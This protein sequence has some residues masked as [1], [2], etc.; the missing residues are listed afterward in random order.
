MARQL[1]EEYIVK[2]SPSE[3]NISNNLSNLIAANV[4]K[5]P[6]NLFNEAQ[7]EIYKLM[8]TNSFPR[9]QSSKQYELCKKILFIQNYLQPKQTH[10]FQTN[11]HIL[12]NTKE[13]SHTTANREETKENNNNIVNNSG[14]I[15]PLANTSS[16]L[17]AVAISPEN[18]V[19]ELLENNVNIGDTIHNS[20]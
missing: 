5:A 20:T 4:M 17:V 1:Y 9:F 18:P 15:N 2:N 14:N 8:K 6:N 11:Q 7:K 3:I 13:K 10:T 12:Y 19:D 16:D